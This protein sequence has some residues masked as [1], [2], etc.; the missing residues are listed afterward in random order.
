M[1]QTSV[2]EQRSTEWMTRMS[3]SEFLNKDDV[4]TTVEGHPAPVRAV[5]IASK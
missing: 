3:L 1:N 4:N 5:V 2:G